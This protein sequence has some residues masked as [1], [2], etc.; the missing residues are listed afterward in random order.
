METPVSVQVFIQKFARAFFKDLPD[1]R[2][3]ILFVNRFLKK[4]MVKNRDIL[5]DCNAIGL[6][7]MKNQVPTDT[8]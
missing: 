2:M 4:N 1:F 6:R 7:R 3:I 8:T 5:P